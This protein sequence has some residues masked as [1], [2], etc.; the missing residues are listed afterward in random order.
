MY[1]GMDH[2]DVDRF[3]LF[4]LT[5][6]PRY[7]NHSTFWNVPWLRGDCYRHS[8]WINVAD[9]AARGIQ[10]GDLV[11]VFNDVGVGVIPACVTNRILP[12]MTSIHH[13]GWYEPDEH[14]VDWGC[15][16]NIF[17]TDSESPVTA[18]RVSNL[19]QIEKY[20][21]PVPPQAAAQRMSDGTRR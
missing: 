5:S 14:G 8:V 3:P 2:P 12:G 21:G 7:R 1:R 13:G 16:P 19:V 11:K 10:D 18:P 15:T 17:L 6:Y 4:L 20:Q 9:A